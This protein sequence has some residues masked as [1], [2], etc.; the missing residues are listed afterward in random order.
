MPAKKDLIDDRATWGR[1]QAERLQR[2]A[3]HGHYGALS[4]AVGYLHDAGD[5]PKWA[6]DE[7]QKAIKLAAWKSGWTQRRIRDLIHYGRADLIRE[8]KERLALTWDD[9][10]EH[11]AKY[12]EGTEAGGSA[13][14]MKS[15]YKLVQRVSETQPW[16]FYLWFGS[17]Q[18]LERVG[19]G[20]RR[21][22]ATTD[23]ALTFAFERQGRARPN[24]RPKRRRP[25]K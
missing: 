22:N 24:R 14:T 5:I 20:G 6:K 17:G 25:A 1:A 2:F 19:L 11:V 8:S 16:R 18:L 9:A 21:P 4:D 12:L 15:S 23:A 3:Q 10:Y 7:I 13:E